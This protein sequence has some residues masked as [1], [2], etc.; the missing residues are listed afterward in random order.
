MMS[1]RCWACIEI[2][3]FPLG[4]SPLVL[5]GLLATTR[6]WRLKL[7]LKFERELFSDKWVPAYGVRLTLFIWCGLMWRSWRTGVGG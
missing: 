1:K 4:Y 6:S 7:T 2:T 5:D 3:L